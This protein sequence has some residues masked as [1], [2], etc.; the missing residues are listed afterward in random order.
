MRGTIM[1]RTG[2]IAVDDT[3]LTW[4]KTLSRDHCDRTVAASTS[5]TGIGGT[6]VVRTVLEFGANIVLAATP[7]GEEVKQKENLIHRWRR[8]R[9]AVCPEPRASGTT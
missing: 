9:R 3:L 7:D 2:P 1:L 5:R 6:T 8:Q 4:E